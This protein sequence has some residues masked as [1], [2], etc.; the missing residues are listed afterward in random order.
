[1]AGAGAKKRVEENRKHLYRLRIAMLVGV[2]FQ[3]LVRILLRGG[4]HSKKHVFGFLFTSFIDYLMYSWISGFAEPVFDTSGELVDGGGDLSGKGMVSY[5]LDIFYV[6]TFV[7]VGSSL[8]L[9]IWYI[10]LCVPAY[11]SYQLY[12][13]IIKPY[14]LTKNEPND[15]PL[16]TTAR[17]K[18]EKAEKRAERRR[19]KWK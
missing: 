13:K 4:Y 17:K 14:L 19:Y 11:A 15:A 1:M 6:N 9:K 3:V 12:F 7:Q 18:L 16:D 5:Y 8:I 10:Y 2:S